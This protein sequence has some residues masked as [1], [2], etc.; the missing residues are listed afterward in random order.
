MY[1]LQYQYGLI[2]GQYAKEQASLKIFARTKGLVKG[3]AESMRKTKRSLKA[4]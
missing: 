3:V 1:S 4:A 2:P